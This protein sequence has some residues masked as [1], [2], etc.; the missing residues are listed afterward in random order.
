M[1]FLLVPHYLHR[2]LRVLA[3]LPKDKRRRTSSAY[4]KIE[5]PTMLDSLKADRAFL[6]Q[7]NVQI[8]ELEMQLSALERLLAVLR[9]ARR[10]AQERLDSY[11]Y[12]L[13][14]L[15]N[16]LIGEIFLCFLPPYPQPP[17]LV[18]RLSPTCLTQVCR[19]WRDISLTTPALWRGIALT[20]VRRNWEVAASLAGLWMQRSGNCPLS[21]HITDY[22]QDLPSLA[23]SVVPHRSRLEHVTMELRT[24]KGLSMIRGPLPLLLSLSVRFI[25]GFMYRSDTIVPLQNLPL[26]ATVVLDD[27]GIP[28]V[29]LPW[30]QMT[31]ITLMCI[32]STHC[33][34]ILRQTPLLVH[35][36]LQLWV[37]YEQQDEF[38]DLVLPRLETLIFKADSRVDVDFF[39]CL[40]TP[41]LLRLEVP[42][43]FLAISA[44]D[45][46]ESLTTF[47]SRSACH[48]R[49]LQVTGSYSSEGAYRNAFPSIATILVDRD[50]DYD[51]E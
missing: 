28:H 38:A 26:L 39:R 42:E 29:A 17:P 48:L 23:A 21:I 15:P 2:R 6:A 43:G 11:T 13:S 35:C 9:I 16:E 1:P 46:I 25:S 20:G 7:T 8:P 32:Y 22:G 18:G 12:P 19:R 14:T 45:P 5:T 3:I 50:S 4:E 41:A 30:S 40:V 36:T 49:E 10:T 24:T 31:S 27:L 37:S 47:I 51:S 34:S 44:C 33:A